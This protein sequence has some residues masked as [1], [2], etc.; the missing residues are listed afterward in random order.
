MEDV[1][2]WNAPARSQLSRDPAG[3]PEI[4][5]DKVILGAV[6][7]GELADGIPERRHVGPELIFQEW[8]GCSY[9]YLDHTHPVRPGDDFRVR[10]ISAQCEDVGIVPMSNEAAAHR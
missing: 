8:T 7:L 10:Q 2:G 5:V 4:A 6:P 1:H 9:R 3:H